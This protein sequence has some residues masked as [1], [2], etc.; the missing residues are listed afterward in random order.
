MQ[1]CKKHNLNLKRSVGVTKAKVSDGNYLLK[2]VS[3]FCRESL[4]AKCRLILSFSPFGEEKTKKLFSKKTF[5][6]RLSCVESEGQSRMTIVTFGLMTFRL[7]TIKI[8]LSWH[9]DSWHF[10]SW[11]VDSWYFD[12]RQLRH[13]GFWQVDFIKKF[14]LKLK[15]IKCW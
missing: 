1:S 11:H 6:D 5:N 4:A 15:K 8:I 9:L 2:V 12:S 14:E 7:M 13:Y 10:D 3:G